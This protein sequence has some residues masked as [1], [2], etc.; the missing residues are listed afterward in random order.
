MTGWDEASLFPFQNH[1]RYRL[2]LSVGKREVC[3]LAAEAFG[4]LSRLAI[5]F[6]N[7]TLSGHAKHLY[8]L[9]GD[10]MAQAGSDGLHSG[11]LGGK[12]GGQ[13]LSGIG[14][15]HAVA[16]LS[17]GEDAPEKTLAKTLHG[18]L[19]PPHFGDVNP[20]PYY[21]LRPHTKVSYRSVAGF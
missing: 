3:A 20:S 18:G 1:V 15:A 14:L 7:G 8:I 11:F 19:D 13:A 10:T 4:E 21:H 17:G 2:L 5:E 9:P 12:S 16:D 6:Q